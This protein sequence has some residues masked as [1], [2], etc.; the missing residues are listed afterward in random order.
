MREYEKNVL[1]FRTGQILTRL[2][3]YLWLIVRGFELGDFELGDLR[4][5]GFVEKIRTGRQHM[6]DLHFWHIYKTRFFQDLAQIGL[7]P[8]PNNSNH[9]YHK[10]FYM[11][12]LVRK[13]TICIGEN[14][15]ADQLRG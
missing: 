9:G 6:T 15:D 13:P 10:C 1:G 14:K 7:S 4:C 8:M 2:Y 11:S 5:S 3:N 12:H